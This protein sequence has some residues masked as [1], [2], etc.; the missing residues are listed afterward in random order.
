MLALLQ[1][2][3]FGWEDDKGGIWSHKDE[4]RNSGHMERWR[5]SLGW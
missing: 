5:G 2:R 3:E 1:E 4:G